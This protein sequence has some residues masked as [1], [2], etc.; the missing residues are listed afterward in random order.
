MKQKPL[1]GF[2][3]DAS[4]QIGT[5][6]VYRCATLAAELRR[7]GWRTA[8]ATRSLP[9][10]L[11]S[12]VDRVHD[13][14]IEL[15]A[16]LDFNDEVAYWREHE[17]GMD[18]VVI[19]H[20]SIPATWEVQAAEAGAR[21]MVIDDIAAGFHA[22]DVLL[23]QNLGFDPVDYDG[24]IRPTATLL[25]GPR[26]ALLRPEFAKAR[27]NVRREAVRLARVL[28]F[29]SGADAHNLTSTVVAALLPLKEL[30]VDVVCGPAYPGLADLQAVV[31]GREKV[32]VHVDVSPERMAV[33]MRAAHVA[34]G[35]ASS[36]SWERACVGLPTITIVLAENQDRV[37]DA[38][39]REGA[40]INLGWHHGVTVE[41]I[42]EAVRELQTSPERLVQMSS[43]A[44]ALTDGQGA[45]RVADTV[46]GLRG[47]H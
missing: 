26:Y 11:A 25:L 23:N 43:R 45:M 19:D 13:T 6:H 24:L 4:V 20:Y 44:L 12:A 5:G 16:T 29:M 35:A 18:V 40:A 41:Q 9:E 14:V 3:A 36:A 42:T 10:R 8:L 2:R 22:A 33:L 7:R 1:A 46:D 27:A 17:D 38:L 34:I 28:V 21:V 15:P 47:G 37:A 30:A 32:T 31:A 39:A